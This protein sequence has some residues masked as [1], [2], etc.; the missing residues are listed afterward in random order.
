MLSPVAR[1]IS[2]WKQKLVTVIKVKLSELQYYSIISE[3]IVIQYD[4][5]TLNDMHGHVYLFYSISRKQEHT[6]KDY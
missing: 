2:L 1:L 6:V 5:M 4:A 3:M